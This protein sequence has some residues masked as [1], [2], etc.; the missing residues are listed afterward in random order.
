M[1]DEPDPGEGFILCS[2]DDEGRTHFWCP[3]TTGWITAG[4]IATAAH[5]EQFYGPKCATHW[6]KPFKAVEPAKET[7]MN[8][9]CFFSERNPV[10][11]DFP[12]AA[13]YKDPS[14]KTELCVFQWRAANEPWHQCFM[15]W[16]SIGPLP[17]PVDEGRRL[18]QE[19]VK[20]ALYGHERSMSD[21]LAGYAA[22][23]LAKGW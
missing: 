23:R 5:C 10:G 4:E 16:R 1:S 17:K 21:F 12:I 9:W 11:E 15:A 18:A 19:Y 8:D 6:R 14:G 3:N 22:G 7:S 13:T 2:A 20:E